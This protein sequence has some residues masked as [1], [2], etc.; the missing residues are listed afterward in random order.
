LRR[1]NRE[2]FSR[3][4]LGVSRR[5][6][7]AWEN[8]PEIQ[9]ALKPD[10]EGIQ[11]VQKPVDDRNEILAMLKEQIGQG[12]VQAAKLLLDQMAT[13]QTARCRRGYGLSE[14]PFEQ[15]AE[16]F[17]WL[18]PGTI[19]T[20]FLRFLCSYLE[21]GATHSLDQETMQKWLRENTDRIAESMIRQVFGDEDEPESLP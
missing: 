3:E 11:E 4:C 6:L 21:E 15:T 2:R 1:L 14:C 17:G 16:E 10:L 7:N 5:T 9:Q 18:P 8:L 13:P 20:L 19:T 12:N